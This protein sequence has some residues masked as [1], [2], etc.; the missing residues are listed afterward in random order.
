MANIL[1]DSINFS[2]GLFAY[3]REKIEELVEKLVDKGSVAK[4]D[5]QSFAS[6]LIQKGE[7][8]RTEIKKMVHSEVKETLDDMGLKK[9]EA[10]LTKE[11]I[12]QIVREEL[13]AQKKD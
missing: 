1:E 11:D 12:R 6:D 5:A 2:V 10:P 4:K 7:E 9:D 8:Q 13:A 3:S